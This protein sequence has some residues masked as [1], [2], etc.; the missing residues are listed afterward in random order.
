MKLRLGV[1]G[2]ADIAWRRALPAVAGLPQFELVA[3]A[4][5]SMEKARKFAAAFGGAAVEGYE[6]LLRR[7]DVDAVYIPL[8]AALHEEWVSRSLE[9]GKHAFVEKP[10]AAGL[11]SAKAMVIK[12][13]SGRRLLM[14]NFAFKHHA[15]IAAV[16][17]LVGRGEIGEVRVLRASFGY[18]PLD[19]ANHRYDKAL[20]GGAL[21]DTGVY[22]IQAA[23]HFLGRGLTLVGAHL[24][25][26]PA[27]GVD[28]RGAAMFASGS[29]QVAQIAFG[30]EHFYRCDLSFWGSTGRLA[31]E[32]AFTPPADMEPVAWLERQGRKEERRFPAQ[33]QFAAILGH[34]ADTVLAG[35]D[36]ERSYAAVLEQAGLVEA[37]MRGAVR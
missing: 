31:V 33:N 25:V 21:L 9:A 19:P 22:G 30:F 13:R 17:D 15:Q 23:L 18:P 1:L 3:V 35:A 20:G 26:D 11:A 14:E 12:A 28:V 29:G 5:R 7:D 6:A 4:S 36:F 2:C 27:R 37:V 32:R 24:H 16:R 8:P 34:F 10:C